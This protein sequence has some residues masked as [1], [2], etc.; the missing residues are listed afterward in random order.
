MS[1]DIDMNDSSQSEGDVEVFDQLHIP[2]DVTAMYTRGPATVIY[3]GKHFDWRPHE[4]NTRA[5]AKT[6]VIWQLGDEY[7]T[8]GNDRNRYWR[9]GICKRSTI[10]VID[11]GSSS[12]LRHLKKKHKIDKEGQRIGNSRASQST[13]PSAFEVAAT[14]AATV[15]NLVRSR[16]HVSFDL[17][18]SP[19]SKGLV[20]VVFHY[21]DNGL[22][23]RS[24]LAGMRRVK[25]SHS[26]ENIAEAVITVIKTI[27][28]KN[29]LS[30][31]IGDNATTNNTVIRAILTH[32]RPDIEDPD[33]R[34]VRCFRYIINLVAKAFLFNKDA[35]AFEEESYSKKT[36]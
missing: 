7:S 26:G 27:G 9:C 1:S 32:L 21:L 24:L 25:G 23:V 11:D 36:R 10:L 17:W 28:I 22:K 14:A 20:G 16:I 35:D 2:A 31:F 18:T 3:K 34:R 12:G 8:R 19:N 30:F 4:D 5:F 15:T 29:Q 13:I 33:F 6:S